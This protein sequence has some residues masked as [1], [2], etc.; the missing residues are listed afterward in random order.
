M[1]IRRKYCNLIGH[2]HRNSTVKF[3]VG[4]LPIRETINM[5][6][7]CK[8][9]R[10]VCRSPTCKRVACDVLAIAALIVVLGTT[11]ATKNAGH[12]VR[13]GFFCDD[14]SIRLPFREETVPDWALVLAIAAI[15]I[16]AVSCQQEAEV[17]WSLGEGR[18]LC[19]IIN[20]NEARYHNSMWL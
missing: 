17:D 11:L 8:C 19:T 13:R 6:G 1:R 14:E 5:A 12:V 10:L 7:R 16:L 4:G 18:G 9:C 3:V 20:V 15:P 2:T